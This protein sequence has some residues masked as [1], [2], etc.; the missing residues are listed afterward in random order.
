MA[1]N[2]HISKLFVE[3]TT[4]CNLKC[5]MCVKQS[6]IGGIPEGSMSP[7][8][9]ERLVPAFPHLDSLVLNGIG[10]P[11][12]HPHLEM[13][14]SNARSHLPENAWVGFQS[15]GMA[16][17][18]ERAASLIDA[19]LD[20]ICISLDTV[21]D[22]SFRSIR[23]GGEM[24]GIVAAF[25]S[26]NKAR[27]RGRGRDLRIGIEFVL[28]RNNLADLPEAIRWAG[29]VGADFAIATQLLPYNKD[30]V[31]QAAYDTNTTAAISIYEHWK[32][33]AQQEDLDI[34]RYLD[35]ITK[36]GR[37]PEEDRIVCLVEKMRSDAE[38][39]G[40]TLHME[41]LLR[42]DEE[43][44]ASAEKVFDEARHAAREA[45]MELTLPGMAP[46]NTR[47]CE[48]VEGDSAFISW[49]GNV[50]PCYFLW[51]RYVCYVGGIEKRVKP[52]TFGNLFD[53]GILDI[54][55]DADSHSFRESVLDYKFPFCFDCG[56]ALCDYVAD[57]DFEQDCYIERV[58]CGACLWCTGLFQC[59][60]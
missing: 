59:L 38:A 42:R 30:M 16:L 4:Y 49:D 44:L 52:W 57:T 17:T 11:L 54:W 46:R 22:D 7:E 41:R 28:M 53:R 2:K 33:K 37:T 24:G 23:N 5:G 18:D 27:V 29:S 12:L 55:N 25:S 39:Q 34:R 6:G 20:R 26:L 60:Q 13:F 9:F 48:F 40:I 3:V 47:K 35:T 15:N 32:T 1:S 31:T 21:S 51:H 56:F 50:H 8:T 43:W 14:I 58:P 45:G 19:G 10:E 36:V